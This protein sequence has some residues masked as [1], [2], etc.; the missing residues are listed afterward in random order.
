MQ[1]RD[2][3]QRVRLAVA[4]GDAHRPQTRDDIPPS[5]GYV[6]VEGDP[7]D[8]M[9][10]EV[11][12]VGGI[13]HRAGSEDA[14][15]DELRSLIEQHHVRSAICWQH[16]LLEELRIAELLAS[17]GVESLTERVLRDLPPEQRRAKMLAADLGITSTTLAIAETGTLAVAS[18]PGQERVA[19]LL[20]PVHVAL[21]RRDQ[22]VPDL[23][24]L[25]ER[26]D[27]WTGEALPT[28]ITLITGP[29]KTGDL[30]LKLTTGV[31]G[32]GEWHVILID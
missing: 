24:D 19:S 16:P 17:L 8:A 15:R 12:Q 25:F 29:S 13:V 26:I 4:S 31:H 32:P 7:C 11:A 23:F 18:A 9:A 6:G 30:E 27:Q 14:A 1:R 20:P 22:I 5:A 2:F 28:N 21:V 3:L 10:G